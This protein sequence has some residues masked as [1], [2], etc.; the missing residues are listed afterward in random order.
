VCF[1]D[2]KSLLLKFIGVSSFIANKK[3]YDAGIDYI[4]C[5]YGHKKNANSVFNLALI[6][7]IK[8]SI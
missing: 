3:T 8:Y 7:I 6:G 2:V 4:N 1:D 5:I